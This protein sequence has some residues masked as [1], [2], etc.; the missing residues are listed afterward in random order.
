MAR[1]G[2]LSTPKIGLSFW[3]ADNSR[4]P[5]GAWP[6]CTARLMSLPENSE[7][8]PWM[9]SSKAPPVP[10]VTHSAKAL[11]FSVWKLLSG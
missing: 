5:I 1:N 3:C 8:L 2:T 4:S 9:T 7:P 10:S 11:P 6:V